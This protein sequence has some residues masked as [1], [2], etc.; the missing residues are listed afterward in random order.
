M[1]SR[2]VIVV[3]SHVAGGSVGGRASVFVLERSGFPVVSLPTVLL[4]WHPGH[5]PSTR[6]VPDRFGDLLDDIAGAPWLG[7][8]GALLSGYLGAAGQAPAVARLAD[9]LKQ[10]NPEAL[11]LCD[12]VIGDSTGLYVPRPTAA[13]IRDHLIPRADILT[14][15]LSELAWLTGREVPG[16]YAVGE[17][18][19]ALAVREV[20]VTSVMT[21]SAGETG[22]ALFGRGEPLLARHPSLKGAPRGT[23]DLF[24]ALFLAARLQGKD[25]RAGLGHATQGAVAMAAAAQRLGVDEMPLAER[26]V[27]LDDGSEAKVAIDRWPEAAV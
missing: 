17:A 2:I 12:P 24:A 4:A 20:V 23:G 6:S 19:A 25:G 18:A 27:D 9:A 7:R 21:G 22:A 5:G 15:N 1:T 8:V 3:N 26:A 11:Y 10:A 16:P 13:G 14:P